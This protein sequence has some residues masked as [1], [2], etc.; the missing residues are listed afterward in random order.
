VVVVDA[1]SVDGTLERLWEVAG[2]DPR[3]RL[4]VVPGLN[5]AEGRNEAIRRAEGELIAVTDGGTLLEPDWLERLLEPI[6]GRPDIAASGGVTLPG[7]RTWFE[8]TLATITTP[9]VGE[10]DPSRYL[11]SSRSVAFRRDWWRRAGG[12]PEW[13][14]TGEDIVL[15]MRLRA[16]G[17][18]IVVATDAI[19]RWHA[20]D[21]LGAFFNQY[22]D[23]ARGDGRAGLWPKRHAARYSAYATGLALLA[24]S[25]SHPWRAA[26]LAAGFAG[27]SRR[28]LARVR[29]ERP[30]A[31]A[32]QTAGA[33]AMVPLVLLVGDAAKMV[34]Y[35]QGRWERGIAVS[36]R[37]ARSRARR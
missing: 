19:V 15:G 5:I 20:R 4:H 16:A 13:L 27:Y 21:T 30:F 25:R 8:R 14:P 23:Y 7:G 17:A 29:E 3:L 1:G 35:A 34:G 24:T 9:R 10:I 6:E 32:A 12:Y 36:R 33:Y 28:C 31:S 18:R 11:P 2:R 26:L 37:R 22:R